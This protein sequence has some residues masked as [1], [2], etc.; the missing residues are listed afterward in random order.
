MSP[1]AASIVESSV[2]VE[3]LGKKSTCVIDRE[4]TPSQRIELLTWLE[5][6]QESHET[7]VKRMGREWGV[8]NIGVRMVA[9]WHQRRRVTIAKRNLAE[10]AIAAREIVL[11]KSDAESVEE[12]VV[13]QLINRSMEV[14]TAEKITP[15]HYRE[16]VGLVVRLREQNIAKERL[17]IERARFELDVAEMVLKHIDKLKA[18]G[19][20]DV[21]DKGE[22]VR[23]VR[24]ALFGRYTSE[25][26]EAASLATA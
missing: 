2:T 10:Q 14:V 1:E 12:A 18:S 22:A 8:N 3:S 21:E 25:Q 20:L 15:S 6:A 9:A 13:A 7:A 19:A 26:I 5:D 4:L 11:A 16:V 17:R 23:K 24:E